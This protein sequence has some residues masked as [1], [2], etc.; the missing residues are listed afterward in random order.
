M[1]IYEFHNSHVIRL[2]RKKKISEIDQ[3]KNGYNK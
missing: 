2:P 1:I 3:Y